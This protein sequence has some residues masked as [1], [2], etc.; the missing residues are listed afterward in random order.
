MMSDHGGHSNREKPDAQT[1]IDPNPKFKGLRG[2]KAAAIEREFPHVVKIALPVGGLDLRQNREIA[3]F[4][5][6]HNIRPRFGK[7]RTV[8]IRDY[9][10]WCFSDSDVADDFRVRFGG[11]PITNKV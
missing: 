4:H 5:R 3:M 9:S 11:E 8:G 6:L 10:R 1:A 2:G 7:R